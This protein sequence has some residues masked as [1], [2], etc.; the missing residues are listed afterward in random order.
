VSG[1]LVVAEHRDGALR[2]VTREAVTAAR[3]L[4]EPVAV[5]VIGA[6]AALAAFD[7]VDELISV[8]G[9]E[10]FDGDAY[11]AAVTA[12]IAERRPT[13]VVAGFTV[14]SMSWAPAV[15]AAT[16]AGFASDV[17][18]VEPGGATREFYGGKVQ[19]ELE[20]PGA[21]TVV[22]LVRPAVFAP[23]ADGGAPAA[24]TFAM[25]GG[26]GRERHIEYR[27]P[28]AAGVDIGAADVVLAIGRGIG[29]RESVAQFEHLAERLGATL[30]ASR[31]VVDAGW[32][33][34]ERQVGQSGRTVKPKLYLAFGISGAVQHLAGMKGSTTIAAVNTDADAAIFGVAHYGAVVDLFEVA[35]ELEKL[36]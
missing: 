8:P 6:D 36:A 24:T 11:R 9:E 14:T 30:A 28:P 18:A 21:E 26:A 29:E 32:L 1:V 4:N 5:V 34:A 20:F 23:A 27:R 15:A 19:G 17:V 13:A 33:P 22:L 12:L 31:P 3:L 7:G 35:E 10:A 25:P 2:E 16:G